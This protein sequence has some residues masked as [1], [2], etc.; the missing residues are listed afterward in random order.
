MRFGLRELILLVVLLALPL[1]S[2]WLV[3][4]PQNAEID[5]AKAEIAHKRQMLEKL[6]HATAQ[7]ADLERANLDVQESIAKI[8]SRLPTNKEV[9]KIVRQ[10][11]QLAVEVGLD[12]PSMKSEKPLP[13]ASYREQPLAMTITGDFRGFYEFLLRLE[14]LPRITRIP[15]MKIQRSQQED[16]HM[17]AEFTL[18]IYFQDD[19]PEGA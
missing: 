16:G 9:D 19:E 2:Y 4:R 10:V 6:R 18:S 3:F 5:L 11:S 14:Q 8:E 17:Q 1:S 15:D 7:N 13:A 12:P